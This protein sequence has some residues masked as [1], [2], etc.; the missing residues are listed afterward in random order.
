MIFKSRDDNS[1]NFVWQA[2]DRGFFEA[3][4]VRRTREKLVVYLSS[5]SG[6]AHRCHMCHLTASGQ[7][8]LRNATVDDL[9]RQAATVLE[10]YDRQGE[11]AERVH[12]NFMARG[13]PLA[14]PH[15]CRD[16][17]RILQ[18]LANLARQREL[19]PLF[20]VSTIMPVSL[21]GKSLERIFPATRPKITQ[22]TACVRHSENGGCPMH[23]RRNAHF[24]CC[25]N[26]SRPRT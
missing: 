21:R 15:L 17:P 25:R 23:C 9:T 1:V 5:Q 12:F 6:C 7:T 26:T 20:L 24:A 22:Y 14:N 8:R 4:Y 13:E 10:W 19:H 3:R 18:E 16:S 11:P 2:G